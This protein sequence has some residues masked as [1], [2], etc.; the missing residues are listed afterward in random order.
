LPGS[1]IPVHNYFLNHPLN[2]PN[3][4]VNVDGVPL[5]AAE[6]KESNLAPDQAAAVNQARCIAR[7]PRAQGGY[8]VGDTIDR[9]SNGFR[10]FEAYADIFHRRFGYDLPVIGTEG[11]AV[12]GSAEDPRYPPVSDAD[13]T[14]LTLEAYH[15]VLDKAPPYFFAQ[16][17]WLLANNAGENFDSRFENAAWYKDRQG[18]VLP[19]VAA[20]KNDPQR[21]Q[22]RKLK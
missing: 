18:K 19:V 3:D 13:V 6:I 2:Y 21:F 15:R 22:S 9:D 17:A 14:R 5:S 11:G 4:P 8:W 7:Q 12:V 16:T 1:W 20:L 10:K